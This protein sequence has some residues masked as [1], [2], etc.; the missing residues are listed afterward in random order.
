[1]SRYGDTHHPGRLAEESAHEEAVGPLDRADWPGP[2]DEVLYRL[3][4]TG[5]W[6]PAI[7]V[8]VAEH[9]GDLELTRPDW[10]ANSV[11]A[12][13]GSHRHGWLLYGEKPYEEPTP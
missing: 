6:V 3:P 10:E 8:E 9:D 7:V 4:I 2:G 5:Q 13:H 11:D 12:K 1:M